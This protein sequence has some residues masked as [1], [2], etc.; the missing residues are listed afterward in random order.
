M[1][2]NIRLP[3]TAG[4]T[5]TGSMEGRA[6]SAEVWRLVYGGRH[7]QHTD[8]FDKQRPQAG[9][10]PESAKLTEKPEMKHEA[11][12]DVEQMKHEAKTGVGRTDKIGHSV[13]RDR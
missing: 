8:I 6:G 9:A 1:V 3:A 7:D 2:L 13:L 4:L 10:Q 12:T 5:C 11:K